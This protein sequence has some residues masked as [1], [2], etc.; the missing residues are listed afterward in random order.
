MLLKLNEN[1]T[2]FQRKTNETPAKS[3]RHTVA[4]EPTLSLVTAP[5]NL[6]G[7]PSENIG[8]TV[9]HPVHLKHTLML[10]VL[11]TGLI[12]ATGFIFSPVSAQAPTLL[13]GH[14]QAPDELRIGS[15]M[16][17]LNAA[18]ARFYQTSEYMIGRVAVGLVLVESDGSIEPDQSTWTTVQR[19]NVISKVRAGLDWWAAR[20]PEAHL[21]FLIDDHATLPIPTGYEPINHAQAAEGLWISDVMAHMGYTTTTYFNRVRTYVNDLR[22]QYQTD[23]AFTIF[24][25]NSSGDPD[26]AFSD[27]YFAYAYVGGPFL[28]MTYDNGNYGI[29]HMD[30]VA[31]HEVGHIF[32][33]LD[34]YASANIP[35]TTASGYLNVENQNSQ[36]PGCASDRPSIMRGGI[37]PYL[38]DAIDPLASGQIGWRDSDADGILDPID[39]TPVL[40]LTTVAQS[41]TLWTYAGYA[42]DQPYPSSTR[43]ALSINTIS[44]EYQMDGGGWLSVPSVSAASGDVDNSLA[45]TL[46]LTDLSVG[47]HRLAFRARNSAGNTSPPIAHMAIV[48]DPLDGGLDTWLTTTSSGTM[49]ASSEPS[50]SGEATS[51]LANGANGPNIARVE[52]QL[53]EGEWRLAQAVDGAFDSCDEGFTFDTRLAPGQHT[54]RARA[55]D[56][57]GKV[58]QRPAVLLL[59]I[60]DRHAVYVPLIIRD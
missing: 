24:V 49:A 36:R 48:P 47:N 17:S 15:S 16:T 11:A 10:V 28:V 55:I 19:Q 46:T 3:Q 8:A 21:S 53:D 32:R 60:T 42:L 18:A 58:E 30:A 34:Q 26:G 56:A 40:T 2:I 57:N 59:S 22:N 4:I 51:F 52:V 12:G 44:A 14:F 43:P 13:E 41:G 9:K 29:D 1:L 50:V 37:S 31:A 7:R 23:W 45:F 33:A 5:S 39:T 25:V 27:G 20:Q 6:N 35:C 38:N 54:I